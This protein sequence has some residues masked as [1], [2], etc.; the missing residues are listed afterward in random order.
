MTIGLKIYDK[1]LSSQPVKKPKWIT[2]L[3]D[4]GAH[5]HCTKLMLIIVHWPEWYNVIPRK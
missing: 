5:Y 4:N 2:I 1:M 3:S